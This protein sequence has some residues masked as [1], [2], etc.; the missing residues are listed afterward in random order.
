MVRLI[1]AI[2]VSAIL[3]TPVAPYAA[4]LTFLKSV[5]QLQVPV[6]DAMGVGYMRTICTAVSI[7]DGEWLTAA[8]CVA[9]KTVRYYIM[10]DQAYVTGADAD[11]DLA[12]LRTRRV[13]APA[14]PISARYPAPLDDVVVAGYP[15]GFNDVN[16]T[17][18]VV[19]GY[20]NLP[21][22]GGEWPVL[23]IAATGAPGNSGSP[24]LNDKGEIVSIVQAGFMPNTFSPQMAGVRLSALRAFL[25]LP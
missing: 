14:L 13:S 25:G 10:G 24:V 16:V 9:E 2:L 20:G 8:H 6:P 22:E 7:G 12:K 1:T 21:Y 17:K 5:V 4:D 19:S 3:L 15:L 18:G 23:M 11:V